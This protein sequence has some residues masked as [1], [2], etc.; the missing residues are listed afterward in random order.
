MELAYPNN[1][2]DLGESFPFR[3][4]VFRGGRLCGGPPTA[5]YPYP[6][7]ENRFWIQLGARVIPSR[8]R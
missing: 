7:D 8:A 6:G 1:R 5:L 4:K 3:L 2:R